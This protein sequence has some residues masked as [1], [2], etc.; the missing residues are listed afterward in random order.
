MADSSVAVTPGTGANIDTVTTPS[1]D[2][3][4]VVIAG[5]RG[6]VRCRAATFRKVATATADEKILALHNATG[7][8]I[9]VDIHKITV[10]FVATAVNTG[11]PQIFRLMRFTTLPTGGTAVT[12]VLEETS[13]GASSAS[14]TTWQ[15]TASDG[16][17]TTSLVITPT[18]NAVIT[19]EYFPRVLTLVG[20]EA[21]DRIEF[22]GDSSEVI[23]LGALEGVVLLA[24]GTGVITNHYIATI[25]WEEYTP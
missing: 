25:A 2:H 3:R 22:L 16:G 15:N 23:T 19:Q 12:K 4:Q 8:T 18:A 5:D 6:G 24:A 10:D 21:A 7:S 20:Y 17:A 9:K 1:G 14:V 11:V 13:R